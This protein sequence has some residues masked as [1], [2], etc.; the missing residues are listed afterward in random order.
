MRKLFFHAA[1]AAALL[2]V[3][4]TGWTKNGPVAAASAQKQAQTDCP[5]PRESAQAVSSACDKQAA[6]GK[7]PHARF[8]RTETDICKKQG[9]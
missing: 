1:I 3:P 5:P 7:E 2:A 4:S 9:S 8:C 6:K